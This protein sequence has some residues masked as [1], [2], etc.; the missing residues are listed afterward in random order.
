MYNDTHI[1]TYVF[2]VCPFFIF[3]E[4]KENCL[5]IIKIDNVTLFFLKCNTFA[6]HKNSSSELHSEQHYL[7]DYI[8]Y[9]DYVY[10]YK[11]HNN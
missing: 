2:A 3:N 6:C 7:N 9:L 10:S 4:R 11:L 1:Y 8:I 5:K